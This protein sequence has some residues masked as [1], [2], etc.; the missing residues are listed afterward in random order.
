MAQGLSTLN[1]AKYGVNLHGLLA[2]S[3]QNKSFKHCIASDLV[4]ELKFIV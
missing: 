1:A 4:D 2:D 3:L